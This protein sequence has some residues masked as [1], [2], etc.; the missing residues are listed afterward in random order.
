MAVISLEEKWTKMSG[1]KKLIIIGAGGHARSVMDIALQNADYEIAGCIDPKPGEVLGKPVIGSDNDLETFFAEGIRHIFVAIGSNSLRHRLF[2]QVLSIGFEPVNV[3]SRYATLSPRS[4]LGKG[5]CIMAGAVI[6]VNTVIDDN[7]IINTRCS[8][9]HD[10]HIGKS[11][12][13]APG[14]TLS[15]T[16]KIGDGVHVGTGASLIDKISIGDWAYIGGGAVV[17]DDIPSGVMAYG[18]PAKVIRKLVP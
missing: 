3:I 18:I 10:C 13:I 17:V 11:S 4:H 1:V 8:I 6:N 7:S 16:V 12:H 2:D 15:G 5:I 9:D 14:V